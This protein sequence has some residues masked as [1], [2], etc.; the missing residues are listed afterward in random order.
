MHIYL[1]LP[2]DEASQQHVVIN[3]HKGLFKYHRLPFGVSTAP[4]IFQRCMDSV[5]Q[6]L[7]GVVAFI[8][9]ILV[10]GETEEE[11]LQ[12][13]DEALQR[14]EEAD[15]TLKNI[16]CS[17]M[18]PEI[19]FLGY[20]IDADGQHP[21]DE[22]IHAIKEA[23]TPKNVSELCAFLGLVNYYSKFLPNLS[24]TL[25]PLYILLLK[26]RKWTWGAE[27]EKT[28]NAA[29]Q[30]LQHNSLLVHFDPKKQLVLACDAS[31]YGIGAVL[32][33]VMEDG[34]ERPIAYTS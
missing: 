13:L 34:T 33:H 32:S 31:P 19:D 4:S 28:F 1:Q 18:Q 23:P 2:L 3:T 12:N 11:H 6:G 21:M 25:R 20:H 5:L 29:K 27:Q 9:D 26:H 22:K 7:E 24:T 16:K 10:T 30:A 15:F 17:F 8:D 14:L